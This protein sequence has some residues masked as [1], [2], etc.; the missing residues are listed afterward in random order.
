M[1]IY[2]WFTRRFGQTVK[3]VK[4]PLAGKRLRYLIGADEKTIL[5]GLSPDAATVLP[6]DWE[7]PFL[8]PFP[9][10]YCNLYWQEGAPD[11]APYL[12][13]TD[14]AE[15]Y[16][17]R[18]IEWTG[19]GFGMNLRW[20]FNKWKNIG[21]IYIELDNPDGY[22]FTAVLHAIEL[23]E[24]YG[25]KVIAKNPGLL[26]NNAARYV[27]LCHGIISEEGAGNPTELDHIRR[28]AGF[29]D[30]P[31]WFVAHGPIGDRWIRQLYVLTVSYSNMGVTISRG[32]EYT[33][34]ET[35]VAPHSA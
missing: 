6:Y 15:Q 3:P 13:N 2:D 21:V 7:G 8:P 1:S 32:G 31:I 27:A 16:G 10:G 30:M 14:T 34:V 20:Q 4:S 22:P 19:P 5:N 35:I 26:K 11:C 28:E 17:E 33:Q 24:S 12:E 25:F 29:P 18:V 9:I 23:A